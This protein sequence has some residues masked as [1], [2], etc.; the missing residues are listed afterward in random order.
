MFNILRTASYNT[1]KHFLNS[2]IVKL[3]P[4]FSTSAKMPVTEFIFIRPK[5]DAQ[6]RKELDAKLPGVLSSVFS[7]IPK[8]DVLCI[9]SKLDGESADIRQQ[10][11]MC[12]FLRESTQ[13]I[14]SMRDSNFI[15]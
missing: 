15:L 13:P 10:D 8:L 14:V 4:A 5:P 7:K 9:G 2:R 6:L 12:L 1:S 11:E 3:H